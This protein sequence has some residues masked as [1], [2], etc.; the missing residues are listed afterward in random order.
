MTYKQSGAYVGA[1]SNTLQALK[2][3]GYNSV[4]ASAAYDFG[5]FLI[6]LQGFNLADN[7]AVT[8]YTQ[9]TPPNNAA[10]LYE[11]LGSDHKAD[12]SY[13]EFQAGREVDLT[14]Q[15]KF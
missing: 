12:Q 3:P 13:Y 10:H 1:Y 8:S 6:K 7:R 15:A 11:I 2:L 14:L 4:D 5:H 9:V